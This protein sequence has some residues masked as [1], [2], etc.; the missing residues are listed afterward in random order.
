MWAALPL[1][2]QRRG[3]AAEFPGTNTEMSNGWRREKNKQPYTS[4]ALTRRAGIRV[5][6]H[7]R[8]VWKDMLTLLV[9][10]KRLIRSCI[11]KTRPRYIW[12]SFLHFYGLET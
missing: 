7:N 1:S 12:D 5:M 11:R 3:I 4:E 2:R 8:I 9:W 10:P 6:K